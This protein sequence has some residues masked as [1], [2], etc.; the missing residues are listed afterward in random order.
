MADGPS[1]FRWMP[2]QASS[3]ARETDALYLFL[4]GVSSFFTIAIAAAIVYF[5]I[6]YRRGSA[7]DRSHPPTHLFYLELTWILVPF[8]LTLVMFVWGAKAYFEQAW[9]PK[10]GIEISCV[11][12][13]WM[14]KFQHPEGNAEIDD[15]HVPL[16]ENVRMTLIS[17]DVI[18]SF[19]VPEFRVKHDVLPGRYVTVWFRPTKAGQYHLFCAEYCGAKHSAMGGVVHV[20]EPS[21]YQL[22]L[23]GGGETNVSPQVAGQQLFEQLRCGTCHEGGGSGVNRGPPLENLFGS[24]V[25]LQNGTTVVADESYLRESIMRPAAKI[26]AGYQPIMPSFEGQIGEEGL[27]QLIAHLKSRAAPDRNAPPTGPSQPASPPLEKGQQP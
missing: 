20:L 27:L 15:L 1:E 8:A 5:A 14:W 3:F 22:W 10:G 19:Y 12:R 25:R 11:A 13:Q 24:T 23:S 17:E 2:E 9:P 7:A 4:I 18:H 26:V 6:K 21:Q 16:G